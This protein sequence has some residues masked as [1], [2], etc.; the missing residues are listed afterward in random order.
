M[1]LIRNLFLSLLALLALPAAGFAAAGEWDRNDHVAVRLISGVESASGDG[2]LP[3]GIEFRL[4][5]GWKI[6]WRTPGDAGYPPQVDWSASGNVGE[7]QMR[8]PV[9][10]R[11][12][13]LGLETLGYKD[14]VLLED[15]YAGWLS[16]GGAV[17]RGR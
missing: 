10:E 15:G 9:P 13:V 3:F 16:V 4:Q 8:W 2:I 12:S 17:S 5:P 11:F 1:R 14:V 6:Y 7:A